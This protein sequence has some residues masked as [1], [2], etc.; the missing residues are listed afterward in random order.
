MKKD[1]GAEIIFFVKGLLFTY[2]AAPQVPLQLAFGLLNLVLVL[3]LPLNLV[4][5]LVKI[6]FQFGLDPVEV[7]GPVFSGLGC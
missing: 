1:L 6:L 2:L 4:F 7:V 3:F 5:H